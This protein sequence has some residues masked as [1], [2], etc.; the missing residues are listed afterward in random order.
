MAIRGL[1][2]IRGLGRPRNDF[3]SIEREPEF[4]VPS[5]D[6]VAPTIN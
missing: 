6:Y 4:R 3:M 5:F 1:G 2:G